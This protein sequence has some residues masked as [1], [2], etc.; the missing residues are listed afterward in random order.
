[1]EPT[2]PFEIDLYIDL[3]TRLPY[4]Y[5]LYEPAGT[6]RRKRG[7]ALPPLQMTTDADLTRF[8][9]WWVARGFVLRPDEDDHAERT[10]DDNLAMELKVTWNDPA[11]QVEDDL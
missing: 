10:I 4:A 3:K 11:L 6:P 5:T 8:G 7:Q 1:L 9:Q 2:L